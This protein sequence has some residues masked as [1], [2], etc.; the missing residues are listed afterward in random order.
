MNNLSIPVFERFKMRL[1]K[2]PK[3]KEKKERKVKIKKS[4]KEI[5]LKDLIN[6]VFK[7]PK[8]IR[9]NNHNEYAPEKT[10]VRLA[11]KETITFS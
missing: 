7:L 5:S 9:L 4:E 3:T 11:K 1:G 2:I 10:T 6:S 8:A